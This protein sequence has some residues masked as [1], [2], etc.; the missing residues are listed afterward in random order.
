MSAAPAL[1]SAEGYINSYRNAWGAATAAAR[2]AYDD[3]VRRRG[4][5]VAGRPSIPLSELAVPVP[6]SRFVWPTVRL[7]VCRICEALVTVK[8]NAPSD[9]MYFPMWHGFDY[10]QLHLLRRC[11]R[12]VAGSWLG[13]CALLAAAHMCPSKAHL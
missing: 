7:W 2:Q 9:R 13:A 5:P 11:I 6:L 12:N 3:A 4:R 1:M 10:P 8:A